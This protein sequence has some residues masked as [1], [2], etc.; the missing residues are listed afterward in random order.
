M[1][2]LFMGILINCHVIQIG[3]IYRIT[4]YGGNRAGIPAF[5]SHLCYNNHSMKITRASG[6]S[7][8]AGIVGEIIVETGKR[9]ICI[10]VC[11]VIAFLSFGCVLYRRKAYVSDILGGVQKTENDGS[12]T[13]HSELYGNDGETKE[14]YAMSDSVDMFLFED[15]YI[16]GFYVD[17]AEIMRIGSQMK[18]ICPSARM[19][20]YNWEAFFNCYLEKNAPDVLQVLGTDPEF[21]MYSAQI[22]ADRKDLADKFLGI[23]VNLFENEELIY[24]FLRENASEIK[25]D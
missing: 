14:V 1:I 25:W 11:L 21:M 9:I 10:I 6:C 16:I 24:S 3:T 13:E 4:K 12:L 15:E 22:P 18:T 23:I 19:S 20:G 8:D 5:A 17:D 2:I 7:K